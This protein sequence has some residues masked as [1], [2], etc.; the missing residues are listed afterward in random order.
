MNGT[1][2]SFT[3]RLPNQYLRV[4]ARVRLKRADRQETVTAPVVLHLSPHSHNPTWR[5]RRQERVS[6]LGPTVTHIPLFFLFFSHHT[7]LD[8]YLRQTV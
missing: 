2:V 7:P 8:M 4:C 1:N 3:E 5:C 6:R